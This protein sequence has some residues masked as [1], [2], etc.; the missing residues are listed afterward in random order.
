MN[1]WDKLSE[2]TE[3]PRP[4]VKHRTYNFL[5]SE[6]TD[7]VIRKALFSKTI[8]P[9]LLLSLLKGSIDQEE[10]LQYLESK[11]S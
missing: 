2:I 5:Y 6:E 1:L 4:E 3:L 7:E 11:F 10:R 9:Y 8:R